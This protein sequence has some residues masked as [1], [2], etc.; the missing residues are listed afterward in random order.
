MF[1]LIVQAASEPG[2]EA[3]MIV[4]AS[5]WSGTASAPRFRIYKLLAMLLFYDP[6]ES[7][8]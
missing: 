8:E 5:N 3:R 7:E 2:G 1:D 6:S 4:D